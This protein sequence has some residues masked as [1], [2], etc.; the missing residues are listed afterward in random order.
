MHISKIN[1]MLG[2]ALI[3]LLIPLQAAL[4]PSPAAALEWVSQAISLP[5]EPGRGGQAPSLSADG[6]FL[7][8]ESVAANLVADDTN[9]VSDVFVYDRQTAST[10][11]VS[12][13]SAGQQA[14][15]WSGDPAISGDG[16]FVAFVS[17]AANLAAGGTGSQ[18]RVF[19]HDR[20]TGT[21]TEVSVDSGGASGSGFNPAISADG[22][23]VAFASDSPALV[24][25][26][27]NAATDVFVRDRLTST[28]TRISRDG[29][30]T[31]GNA[32]SNA[33]AISADGRYVSFVSG[34]TNLVLNDTNGE[35]DVFVHDRQTGQIARASVGSTGTQADAGSF[36]GSSNWISGDGRFVVFY[37]EASNLVPGDSNGTFDAFVRDRQTNLT[38]RIS[39]SSGG[40]EANGWSG[41]PSISADGQRAAFWS[42]ASN[43]VPGDVLGF[44]DIFVRDLQS[45]ETTRAS[46]TNAGLE[47]NAASR[48]GGDATPALNADGRLVAFASEASNL[49]PED[50]NDGA[51]I[52]TRDLLSA[53][54]ERSPDLSFDPSP[55]GALLA[56]APV[57][58]RAHSIS[59]NGRHVAF[60]SAATNLVTDDT[61][62]EPDVFLRDLDGD[63]TVLASVDS[64]GVAGNG[65][66]SEAAVSGDGRFVVFSSVADN[67]VTGDSNGV[68]DIFVHDSSTGVTTRVSVDGSGVQSDQASSAPSISS[69]GRYVAFV[70]RASNLVAGGSNGAAQV[71]VH[72][73]VSGAT[74]R[75]SVNDIG[76]EGDLPSSEPA[77]SSDGRFVVFRSTATTLVNVD[78]NQTADI[79][80]RDRQTGTT[81]L[82]SVLSSGNQFPSAS[83]T[84]TISDDGRYVAFAQNP[85]SCGHPCIPA[86]AV[87][88]RD[89]QSASTFL[90]SETAPVGYVPASGPV[91]SRDGRY[92]VYVEEPSWMFHCDE[93][94]AYPTISYTIRSELSSG[95]KMQ[96]AMSLTLTESD[97]SASRGPAIS[98]DGRFVA[99]SSLTPNLLPGGDSR[100]FADL[101]VR[102]IAPIFQNGFETGDAAAWS[103]EVP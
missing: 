13:A 102:E 37:S 41:F 15:A 42:D 34:A 61:N 8:L 45:G 80:L 79:F 77:I 18:P 83:E 76:T 30:G 99:F 63:T 56:D 101:F 68:R 60:D 69:D 67:L 36:V 98:E 71:Y 26:D 49:V 6:R 89:R 10:A 35:W 72:D 31:Q 11:R 58:N 47:A 25:G 19:V 27:S 93:C 23:F 1:P 96:I 59:G 52:F 81:T 39:V 82:V 12:V 32:V 2:I 9:G 40:I 33:P 51:D 7:A 21:T 3:F 55:G 70:S 53:T 90:A 24:A 38:S 73:A 64:L 17:F 4:P 44:S 48:V 85:D 43:L 94:T 84:P 14:D 86:R 92:L 87:F 5:T 62:G 16:R 46:L 75:V 29:G 95:T 97:T 50:T 103:A 88:V 74:S 22:R 65:E 20:Q 100:G 78:T 28:T 57:V 91:L 66:S 54:T